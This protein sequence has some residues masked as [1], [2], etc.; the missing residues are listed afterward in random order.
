MD[1]VNI[2]AFEMVD[3]GEKLVVYHPAEE[4]RNGKNIF[5]EEMIAQKGIEKP[6]LKG[7]GFRIASDGVTYFAQRSG[8]FE[9]IDDTIII[10]NM[11]IVEEDITA[12]SGR[13]EIDGSVCVIGSVHSGGY[14]KATG[15]IVVEHNMEQGELIA[16]GNVIIKRGSCSKNNCYITAKGD[17]LGRFFEAANIEAGGNVRANYIMYSHIT[18]MGKVIVSGTKGRILGGNIC[19]V[20]GVDT[21]DIGNDY[22][23]KGVLEVGKNRLYAQ[24]KEEFR[25]KREKPMNEVL[26]LKEK[27]KQLLSKQVEIPEDILKKMLST[28]DIKEQELKKIES[29]EFRFTDM[30]NQ[31]EIYVRGTVYAGTVVYIDNREHIVPRD[32]GRIVFRI[33]NGLVKMFQI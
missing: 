18:T 21:Y 23:V 9:F 8:K 1:Y 2:E 5:G 10:S 33:R 15:D 12:V 20:M 16:G 4:G 26:V 3:E 31:A 19:A 30:T 17:V 32:V 11:I 25:K 24:R 7:D 13:I 27:L 6:A 29:E 14:I 22:G 28:I